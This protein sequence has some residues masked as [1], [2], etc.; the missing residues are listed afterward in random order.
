MYVFLYKELSA[1]CDLQAGTP[2]SPPRER[3]TQPRG[4]L[5]V[6][7]S[8]LPVELETTPRLRCKV[9]VVSSAARTFRPRTGE[10]GGLEGDPK[11]LGFGTSKTVCHL[12][13][14]DPAGPARAR[15]PER[16]STRA[17]SPAGRPG[18]QG[19]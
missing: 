18:A 19:A 7:E 12:P 1:L 2:R 13:R 16:G 10:L 4:R 15:G 17:G 8:H 5:E 6:P 3:G 9:T 11:G 14:S